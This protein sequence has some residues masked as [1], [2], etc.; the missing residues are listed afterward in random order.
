MAVLIWSD[1]DGALGNSIR[2]GRRVALSAEEFRP[3]AEALDRQLDDLL[4]MAWQALAVISQRK[5]GLSKFN[6]FEQVWVLGR[7]VHLS[8]VMRH[9]AMQGEIRTL[10]WQALTPK[11]WYGIRHDGE[12]EPR[13]RALIPSGKK[14]WRTNPN[15]KRLDRVYDFLEIGYWLR[16]QQLHDAGELFGWNFENAKEYYFRTALRSIALRK[17]V[18]IW[19]R[20]QSPEFREFVKS[21]RGKSGFILIPKALRERFPATGPGSALLPQ[22]YPEDELRDIVCAV[23]DAARDKHFQQLPPHKE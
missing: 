10:L 20:R 5:N 16:E 9:E 18:L 11:A 6:S 7:A 4:D 1:R 3:E 17:A 23:L 8:E 2:S 22:H 15:A 19:L 12:S 21:S 14:Q 13:W